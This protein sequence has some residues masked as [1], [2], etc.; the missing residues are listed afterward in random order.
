M[1]KTTAPKSTIIEV[2]FKIVHSMFKASKISFFIR[3]FKLLQKLLLMKIV[4]LKLKVLKNIHKFQKPKV[5][6]SI[7]SIFKKNYAGNGIDNS[8][9]FKNGYNKYNYFI[10]P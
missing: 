3:F 4:V 6:F 5:F 10:I 2:T 1:M 9:C 8:I 7:S